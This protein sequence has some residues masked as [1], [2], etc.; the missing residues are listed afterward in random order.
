MWN[1]CRLMRDLRCR[2]RR[3]VASGRPKYK[4]Y[5]SD[6]ASLSE[7]AELDDDDEE[8]E[9]DDDD[10]LSEISMREGQYGMQ[11]RNSS[12]QSADASHFKSSGKFHFPLVP[13]RWVPGYCDKHADADLS[14]LCAVMQSGV[15]CTGPCVC[16]QMHY[17]SDKMP[18][19]PQACRARMAGAASA[20]PLPRSRAPS[21]CCASRILKPQG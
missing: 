8:D 21:S 15:Y 12:L 16:C 9:D 19:I 20:A 1:R 7:S 2:T 3:R 13:F 6:D 4:D 10:F 5:F 11:S 17:G 18:P 14:V